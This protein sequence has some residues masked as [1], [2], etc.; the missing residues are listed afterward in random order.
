LPGVFGYF[1]PERRLSGSTLDIM[2]R[3]LGGELTRYIA[4]ERAETIGFGIINYA[5][6]DLVSGDS[7]VSRYAVFGRLDALGPGD[8]PV[9]HAEIAKHCFG[10]ESIRDIENIRGSYLAVIHEC[11]HGSLTLLSDRFASQPLYLFWHG[12]VCYFASQLKSIL[13]VLPEKA[14]VDRESVAT[15]LSMGE[16]IGNRTLVTGITTLPAATQLKFS[17]DANRDHRYWQYIYEENTSCDWNQA[18]E[19]T[20][21][22]LRTAVARCGRTDAPLSSLAVPLSGGLD[23]RFILDLSQQQGFK[24]HAYTWGIDGCRDIRYAQNAARRLGCP[25][26]TY[27]FQPDYLASMAEL[28]VWLTEGHASAT[29]FHVLPYV[30][31]LVSQGHDLLLDGFAGDAVL[32]GNFI[33]EAW[34]VNHDIKECANALWRWRRSGFDGFWQ[35]PGLSDERIVAEELFINAYSAYSGNTPMDKAMAFLIDNRVRR[36]TICGTEIFRSRLLLRQPFMDS[37]F[38]DVIRTIPHQWRKRH[39]FYLAVMKKFAPLSASAPYQRTMLPVSFPYWMNWLSLASQ[40]GIVEMAKRLGLPDP[41]P[42]KSPSNFPSWIR[43]TL[44]SF[45]ESVLLDD[46]TLDRGVI[47]ADAVRDAVGS[48][49]R[50][51]QDLSSLI[52]AMLSVELFCRLFLDDLEGSISKLTHCCPVKLKGELL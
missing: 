36:T 43:E 24:P 7:A 27:I 30:D 44:R 48:H 40:R 10:G 5:G 28:G 11:R 18:I 39:R 13:A 35:H 21:S 37:D 22:A 50:R 42:G 12:T 47:P 38:I 1:D 2:A 26:K 15:M 3:A 41:Y 19:Q 17:P 33:S 8:A 20:G 9:P 32:G 46:R 6:F 16:V 45:V 49:M 14:N 23:S 31:S 34:L 52:G 25:H 29:N 4:F 51:E